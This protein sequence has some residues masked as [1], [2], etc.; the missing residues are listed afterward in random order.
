MTRI[1]REMILDAAET[2]LKFLGFDTTVYE[3]PRNNRKKR[4]GMR[5]CKMKE[6]NISRQRYC[7]KVI[8]IVYINDMD[9]KN[10]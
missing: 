5:N 10:V 7:N 6:Q 3:N 9:M 4:N 8:Q 1:N 2:V